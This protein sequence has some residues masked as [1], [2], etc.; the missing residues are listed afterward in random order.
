M[1]GGGTPSTS[2]RERDLVVRYYRLR[3][4]PCCCC[5]GGG[6]GGEVSRLPL[7]L[8]ELA[9]NTGSTRTANETVF[10]HGFDH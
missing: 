8:S 10:E 3:S 9:M 5:C 7:T 4:S 1:E 2:E 6:G